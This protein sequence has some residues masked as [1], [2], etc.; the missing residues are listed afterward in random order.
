MINPLK[1][2]TMFATSQ[3]GSSARIATRVVAAAI[4][5]LTT[6]LPTTSR[7][8]AI[9]QGSNGTVAYGFGVQSPN[10]ATMGQTFVGR[11]GVLTGF[12]FWLSNEFGVNTPNASALQMRGYLLAWNGSRAVGPILYSSSVRT[13]PV[14]L[15]QQYQFDMNITM[16]PGARYVAFLS[17]SGLFASIA[18]RP[19]Q[20]AVWLSDNTSSGGAFVYTNSGDDLG[21]VSSADWDYTG[22]PGFQAQF[23]ATFRASVVPEPASVM[24]M[25]GGLLLLCGVRV[26][27]GRRA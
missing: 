1:N 19:A 11:G 20:T 8:Q 14:A 27:R 10:V 9:N 2:L 23:Q 25:A 21:L 24:L 16:T 22:D 7:A 18:P 3:L 12:S 15:S 13:G 17:T 26:A 4:V 6:A 5:T